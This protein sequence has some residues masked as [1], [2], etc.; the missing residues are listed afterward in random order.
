M[1]RLSPLLL[2]SGACAWSCQC[3]SRQDVPRRPTA[4]RVELVTP[5]SHTN[6]APVQS[7]CGRP[8]RKCRERTV[9]TLVLAQVIRRTAAQGRCHGTQ[10]VA[11]RPPICLSTS[12]PSGSLASQGEV[13]GPSHPGGGSGQSECQ[14]VSGP[15]VDGGQG[16]LANP[17]QARCITTGRGC[18]SGPSHSGQ[19]APGLDAERERVVE[20]GLPSA[21]VSTIQS[22]RAH[23]K[24]LQA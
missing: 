3:Q 6:V 13:A 1:G 4:R 24:G 11:R 23:N 8:F 5:N 18:P 20:L 15:G 17:T 9:P 7:S 21:V 2:E 10:A 14:V 22:V 16:S 19:E 12:L